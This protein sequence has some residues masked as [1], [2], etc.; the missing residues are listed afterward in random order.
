MNSEILYE[1]LLR[2]AID[3]QYLVKLLP[4][5]PYNA[6]YSDQ[7]IRSSSSPG[8]NYIEAI[9]ALSRKDFI[10]R[11]RISR[12]ETKESIHWLRLIQSANEIPVVTEKTDTLIREAQELIRIFTSSIKTAERN[13]QQ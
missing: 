11:L 4:K 12:K 3:C 5:A 7:L 10:H 9:E 6:V 8:S 2:F 13:D 1:R